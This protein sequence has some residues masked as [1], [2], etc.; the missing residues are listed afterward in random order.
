MN[1]RVTAYAE[2]IVR[3]AEGEDALDAVDDEL[4]ELARALRGNRELHDALTNR[5]F[6]VS[7]RLDVLDEVLDAAHPATRTAVS[8][9]V[10]SGRAR[11]LEEIARLVAERAAEQRQRALAEVWVAK[12]LD[13]ERRQRLREALEDAT[14]KTV[15]LKVYVD[16]AVIGG[17]RAKIGDLVIDGTVARRLDTLKARL[18]G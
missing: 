8:M 15:E 7:R 5:Q 16:P 3:I 17:V 13:Q 10:A 12:P 14:G 9:L 4:L 11:D 18:G 2:A 1:D 6:P